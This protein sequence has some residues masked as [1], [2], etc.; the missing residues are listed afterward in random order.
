MR[1]K[2]L[3]G[4]IA[5][6]QYAALRRA[7]AIITATPQI[8]R[9]SPVLARHRERCVTI[10]FGIEPDAH[11]TCDPAE[12]DAIRAR[13]SPDG[14]PLVLALGRLVYYKGFEVL[15]RAMS[16]VRADATLLI[17]GEG[18]Q[19]PLLE[20]EIARRGLGGRVRLL[21]DLPDPQ[22]YFLACDLFVLPSTARS[23]AFGIVQLEAMAC[24]KPV[25]NT[26][27]DSGVPFVSRDGETG[28]T[29]PPGD[30]AALAGAINALLDDAE[31]RQRYGEAA[32]ERVRTEFNVETMVAAT[33]D[34][35]ERITGRRRRRLPPVA[36]PPRVSASAALET[37]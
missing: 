10:P 27:L 11:E 20:A 33:L 35:Y 1:Q 14:A 34:L 21:G 17:I 28:L 37:L 16:E 19:R 36:T 15:V 32:R 12:V 24:G 2:F 31:L 22:P 9:H 13:H 4:L 29:V 18:K 3:G 8:V 7:D 23:E 6:L 26:S 5:P 25:I 30:A